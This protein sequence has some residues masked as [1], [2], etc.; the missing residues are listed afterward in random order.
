MSWDWP[1][2]ETTNYP[3]NWRLDPVGNLGWPVVEGWQGIQMPAEALM[4][5]E[6]DE[7]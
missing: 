6:E 1:K 4:P 5:Q 7:A 2:R 3:F